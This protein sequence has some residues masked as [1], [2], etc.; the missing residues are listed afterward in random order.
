[1]AIFKIKNNTDQLGKRHPR[2]NTTQIIEFKDTLASDKVS[3]APG[4]EIIVESEFLPK[5]AHKLRTEGF[6]TVQEIDKNTYQRLINEKEAQK[7]LDEAKEAE[8]KKSAD[9][10]KKK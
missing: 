2:Y 3:V 5:S 1:M 10:P 8:N 4:A 7:S 9:K 6:I